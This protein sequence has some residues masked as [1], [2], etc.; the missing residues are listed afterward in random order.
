MRREIRTYE[1]T[2]DHCRVTKTIQTHEE[3]GEAS[4]ESEGWTVLTSPEM[5]YFHTGNHRLYD[6]CPACLSK[7]KVPKPKGL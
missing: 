5:G 1:F 7:V 6:T 2:C 3:I 4:L